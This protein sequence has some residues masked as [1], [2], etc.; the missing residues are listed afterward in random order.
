LIPKIIHQIW[1]GPLRR[2]ERWMQ[3]WR[4]AHPDWEY[5]LWDNAKIRSRKFVNQK[6]V[7][8]FWRSKIWHG[9][10]DVCRYEILL[11]YG[12]F[13][14]EADS[15]CRLPVDELFADDHAAY[16]VY[17]NEIARPGLISPLTACC[18]GSGF[19]Q[20]LVDGLHAKPTVGE[21]WKTT[22]NL[23]MQEMAEKTKSDL[24]IWPS[25]FFNPIHWTGKAYKGDGKVYASQKWGTT[26]SAY[27]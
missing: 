21:P 25:H 18:P 10:S 4:E 14:P 13:M 20:E 6:H 27:R 26:K 11:E 9:V 2:P 12:G 5:I 1:V 16:G 24:K 19:A 23:Y 15:E 3:T 17:E 8:F 7:D 22:G